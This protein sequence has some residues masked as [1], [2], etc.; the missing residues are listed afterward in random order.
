MRNPAINPRRPQ[1]LLEQVAAVGR[2][3]TQRGVI[4][5]VRILGQTSRNGREYSPQA[6]RQ[7]AALYEGTKCYLDHVRRDNPSA[8]RSLKDWVGVLENVRVDGNCVRGDLALIKSHPM[9]P[10]ILEAAE[11]RSTRFGLSHNADGQTISRGGKTIVESIDRV[12]SVDLVDN[13]ATNAGLFE[14][15]DGG[16][17]LT[18]RK[19]RTAAQLRQAIEVGIGLLARNCTI[20]EP[21]AE[22][23]ANAIRNYKPEDFTDHQAMLNAECADGRDPEAG[24]LIA[25]KRFL[26]DVAAKAGIKKP[27]EHMD[28]DELTKFSAMLH[29]FQANPGDFSEMRRL[30]PEEWCRKNLDHRG[31]PR[32]TDDRQSRL[33]EFLRA[34]EALRRPLKK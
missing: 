16:S 26:A 19:P 25:T 2:V 27:I 18:Q 24:S 28:I 32:V 12:R 6:L 3:D 29:M 30:T 5:G 10:A 22:Y 8:S 13:P 33:G 1:T 34:A 17:A 20:T 23:V 11:T 31:K 21:R 7:A 14:D 9:S 15:V 4:R